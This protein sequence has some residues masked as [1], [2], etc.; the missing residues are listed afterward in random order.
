MTMSRSLARIAAGFM[1]AALAG[2]GGGDDGDAS[3]SPAP[4]ITGIPPTVA[5]VGVQYMYDFTASYACGI[6]VCYDADGVQLPP[7]AEIDHVYDY[8]VWY[9]TADYANKD[10]PF[11]IATPL[12]NCIAGGGNRAIQSW[13]VHV[14][15]DTTPL[16]VS[17]VHP[18]GLQTAVSTNTSI[19][20]WFSKNVDPL[21]ITAT[22]F[23]VSSP[24]G[25]VSGNIAVSTYSATL[26]PSANLPDFSPITVT[27]TTAIKDISGNALTSN[28]TWNFTTGF[29]VP[30]G[31]TLTTVDNSVSVAST[32]ITLDPADRT[33]IAY[34]D[35][36]S[37]G[38]NQVVGDVKLATNASGSWQAT[39][40][41]NVAPIVYASISALVNTDNVVHIGYY[42]FIRYRLR[43]AMNGLGGWVAEDVDSDALNVT[44]VSM[45]HDSLGH[46]HVVY[47]PSGIVTYAT[48][49]S[50]AWAAEVIGNNHVIGG[51]VTSAI[52]IDA[53]D[54]IHV[55]YYDYSVHVLKHVTNASGVWVTET[56]DNQGDVGLHVSIV[57]NT[58]GKMHLSYY[59]STNGDLK[60]ASN[61]SGAWVTQTLD[62]V[63][64]VGAATGIAL[65]GS[66][67][68]HIS[69]TDATKH[70]LNYATNAS[71]NWATLTID[72]TAYVDGHT[73]IAV[74]SAGKVHISYRGDTFLRYATNR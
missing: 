68:V 27:L 28:Y 18:S 49:A 22:S 6:F 23:V 47:N 43:H 25:P 21:S 38:S 53:S 12:D 33:Y 16:T 54:K 51:G 4:Q 30:S 69:Y 1:L 60:Y 50:G 74:D 7:G 70:A 15:P 3:C 40:V 20:A 67:N 31:W 57:A 19:T 65:D 17:S 2:C 61:A 24:A 42:D 35:A 73:S 66:G 34:Q 26:T 32:A 37:T 63:G 48:N 59:D 8:L 44:T 55:A 58:L 14:A 36:R 9:P 71:G 52:A 5:T 39:V 72:D 46:L 56:I 11:A 10:V 64:D 62:N 45:A 13:T 29:T 41:D